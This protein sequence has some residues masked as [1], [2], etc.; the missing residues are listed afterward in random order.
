MAAAYNIGGDPSCQNLC[1]PEPC[2][3]PVQCNNCGG[4]Y[5]EHNNYVH[6]CNNDLGR[7]G[8][9]SG[10]WRPNYGECNYNAPPPPIGGACQNQGGQWGMANP[11]S[12][13]LD[14]LIYQ[15]QQQQ[16]QQQ[17]FVYM[18]QQTGSIGGYAYDTSSTDNGQSL[19]LQ[20]SRY[21]SQGQQPYLRQGQQIQHQMSVPRDQ[22]QGPGQGQGQ[23]QRASWSSNG[24]R[25]DRSQQNDDNSGNTSNNYQQHQQQHQQ[26]DLYTP[27]DSN[28]E[29]SSRS[30][31]PSQRPPEGENIYHT[32]PQ[33]SPST[34]ILMYSI[35]SMF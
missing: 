4:C 17:Q 13:Y 3:P 24:N 28:G 5:E 10:N 33:L 32:S 25:S 34:N 2:P 14:P 11:Y 1:P 16:Q 6:G 26:E 27:L 7:P 30:S 22:G 15:Q 35:Y 19:H 21:T 8:P 23:G 31:I 18:Q 12:T 20:Q 29:I 9:Y